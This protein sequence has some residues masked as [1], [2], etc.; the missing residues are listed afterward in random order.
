MSSIILGALILSI[1]GT[2][3][4][5]GKTVGLSMV[6]FIA[7]ITL[8]IIYVL[9][10]N[11]KIENPKAKILLIPIIILA[12][13]Y[14]IYNNSFFNTLNILVIPTLLI[15]MILWLFNEKFDFELI[16]KSYKSTIFANRLC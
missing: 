4:F 11:G 1:W 12:S 6:L 7:P 13:T 2:L 3:L 15:I 9:E 14:C 5:F 10:K 8:F 16:R